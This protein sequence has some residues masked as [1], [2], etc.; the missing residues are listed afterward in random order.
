[1]SFS[2]SYQPTAVVRARCRGLQFVLASLVVA[3]V[4]SSTVA[5]IAAS[6][7]REI[8]ESAGV[9]DAV[10]A[11]TRLIDD[12]RAQGTAL[13]QLYYKRGAAYL[14]KYQRVP[15]L[16]DIDRAIELKPDLA[17]A[18]I[19][20]ARA[21]GF[22]NHDK[23]RLR[24][25][26]A[27]YTKAIELKPDSYEAFYYRGT[28]NDWQKSY[29][30]ALADY[31]RALEIKGDDIQTL[32]MR[33]RLYQH[34]GEYERALAD[35]EALVR[36]DPWEDRLLHRGAAYVAVGD[37]ERALADYDAYERRKPGGP[38]IH[39]GRAAAFEAKGDYERALSEYNEAIRIAPN[40]VGLYS[41]R[42]WTYYKLGRFTEGL[43]DVDQVLAAGWKSSAYT[44]SVR[45]HILEAMGRKAAAITDLATALSLDPGKRTRDRIVAALERLGG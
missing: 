2:Y 1:M 25:V 12:G 14:A 31:N 9:D 18:Y 7:D 26:L 17:E 23:E 20:R 29:D 27:D 13:G 41:A 30:A 6:G 45:G 37:Y 36:H 4:S 28:F 42:A 34:I 3:A 32:H 33:S 21:N 22:N 10:A 24:R 40:V 35:C 11:C 15:G 43:A 38:S 39:S 5:A 8:C 44:Y 16:A 19:A